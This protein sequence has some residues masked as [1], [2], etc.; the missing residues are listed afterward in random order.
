M[1]SGSATVRPVGGTRAAAT[2]DRAAAEI[3]SAR[4]IGESFVR[5]ICPGDQG[6]RVAATEY[7][8]NRHTNVRPLEAAVLGFRLSRY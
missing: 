4:N 3:A 5:G 7:Q 8:N 1:V 6:I 2:V